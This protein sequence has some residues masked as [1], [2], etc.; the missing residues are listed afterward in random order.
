M[1]AKL[2][3]IV[4]KYL[5]L[6][7]KKKVYKDEYDAKVAELDTAMDRIEAYMLKQMGE[8][9]LENLPTSAGTA[10]KSI[11]TSATVA[12]WDSFLNFVKSNE[13]WSMLERRAAKAAVDEFVT[14]NG[15]LPP[16]ININ[17]AVVCNIRRS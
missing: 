13:A 2:D 7:D 8:Q 15:D 1:A 5:E 4:A 16:G 9:G 3:E 12:D 6:R 14:A 11:R 17:R 10:Y